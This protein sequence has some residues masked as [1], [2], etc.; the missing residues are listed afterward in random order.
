MQGSLETAISTTGWNY[1]P[2]WFHKLNCHLAAL[3]KTLNFKSSGVKMQ[4]DAPEELL[5]ECENLQRTCK[6]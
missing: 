4:S 2:L 6:S 5:G 1:L 3:K